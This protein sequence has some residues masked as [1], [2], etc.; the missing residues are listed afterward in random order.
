VNEYKLIV[1]QSVKCPLCKKEIQRPL[2]T[3]EFN[4]YPQ[5][6]EDDERYQ[7]CD[8]CGLRITVFIHNTWFE[9]E[10]HVE[11]VYI[12]KYKLIRHRSDSRIG[13]LMGRYTSTFIANSI[14]EAEKRLSESLPGFQ[15]VEMTYEIISTK[16]T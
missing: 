4:F 3:N 7:M 2:R 6:E 13:E 9:R 12:L 15:I 16:S 8:E 14:E 1:N 5:N 11:F 10:A